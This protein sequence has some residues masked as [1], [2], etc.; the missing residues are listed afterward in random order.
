MDLEVD[1]PSTDLTPLLHEV[2]P[3]YAVGW[4]DQVPARRDRHVQGRLGLGFS[5]RSI[6]FVDPV[7]ACLGLVYN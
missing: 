3:D 4:H 2:T 7:G 1:D 5:T 6:I